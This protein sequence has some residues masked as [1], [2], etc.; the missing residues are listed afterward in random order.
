MS[1]KPEYIEYANSSEKTIK[2]Y[3]HDVLQWLKDKGG[4]SYGKF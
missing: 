4:C 3:I 2:D 1:K